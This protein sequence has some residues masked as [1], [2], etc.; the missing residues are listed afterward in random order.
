MENRKSFRRIIK[1]IL[2]PFFGPIIRILH[3]KIL[4]RHVFINKYTRKIPY[5]DKAVRIVQLRMLVAQ[6]V[7]ERYLDYRRWFKQ[8]Y[9]TKNELKVD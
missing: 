9:P 6:T 5:V 7:H 1:R 8:H 3:L 4:G 2:K